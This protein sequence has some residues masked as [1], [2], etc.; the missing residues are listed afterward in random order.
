MFG[1]DFHE[2]YKT[3]PSTNLRLFMSLLLVKVSQFMQVVMSGYRRYNSSA[4]AV[5][6]DVH[7]SM[8][9]HRLRVVQC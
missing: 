1:N 6:S 8:V 2:F 3:N 7:G 5:G 9:Q 4:I